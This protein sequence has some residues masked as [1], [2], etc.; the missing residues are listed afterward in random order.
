MPVPT[1]AK[2]RRP[3]FDVPHA[4]HE[5][6]TRFHHSKKDEAGKPPVVFVGGF[7]KVP[8][9]IL[10]LMGVLM[11]LKQRGLSVGAGF[12]APVNALSMVLQSR[13]LPEPMAERLSAG[14]RDGRLTM[15]L[16]RLPHKMRANVFELCLRAQINGRFNDV[17]VMNPAAGY[18]FLKEDPHNLKV[19]ERLEID[20]KEGIDAESLAGIRIRN[21]VMVE[22]AEAHMAEKEF[23]VYVQECGARHVY[24]GAYRRKYRGVLGEVERGN[25]EDGLAALFAAKGHR[26]FT[27]S[28]FLMRCHEQPNITLG[29]E[30]LISN[31]KTGGMDLVADQAEA[32][33]I[34]LLS[35]AQLEQARKASWKRL[36]MAL[37]Q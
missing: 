12:E 10:V 7:H 35:G 26:V 23:D 25:P 3:A 15:A 34:P 19:A 11:D 32:L 13:G 9:Y 31:S 18:D 24:E 1:P 14:D 27:M 36:E 5:F 30:F 16:L 8:E 28:P 20:L 2:R 33:G 4:L 21:H 37:N 6:R 17:A 29:L 22:N